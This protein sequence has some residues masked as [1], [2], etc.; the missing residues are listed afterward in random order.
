MNKTQE[1]RSPAQI[2]DWRYVITPSDS[3]LFEKNEIRQSHVVEQQHPPEP[4]PQPK[5]FIAT[6]GFVDWVFW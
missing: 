3:V 4:K 1:T 5:T 6:K 2:P